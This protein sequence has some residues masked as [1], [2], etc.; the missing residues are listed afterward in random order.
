[1]HSWV[2]NHKEGGERG[3]TFQ[4][5][6]PEWSE[7]HLK[8]HNDTLILLHLYKVC[9]IRQESRISFIPVC[10]LAFSLFLAMHRTERMHPI[11]LCSRSDFPFDPYSEKQRRDELRNHTTVLT[12]LEPI[13]KEVVF[14]EVQPQTLKTER[15]TKSLRPPL[16]RKSSLRTKSSAVVFQPKIKE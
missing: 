13:Q 3:R 5:G 6:S 10:I 14:Q 12:T 4:R 15:S 16:S 2:T 11:I 9:S 1:M 7:H 8:S